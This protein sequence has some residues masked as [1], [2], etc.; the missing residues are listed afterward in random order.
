[1]V[2]AQE[3]S[4]LLA[5]RT[6]ELNNL[7]ASVSLRLGDLRDPQMVPESQQFQLITGSPPYIPLGKGVVSP[8]PQRAACRMELRGTIYDYAQTAERA[9]APGGHFVCCFA[10]QDPRAEPAISEAGLHLRWRTDVYFREI[11]PPTICLLVATREPGPILRDQLVIRDRQ[12]IWT[13][14]YLTIR[15]EMGTILQATG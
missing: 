10:G 13:P 15:Q 12:G 5:R 3:V 4:H 8:H 2:E 7:Q 11:L 14:D 9:L 6:V 1:M